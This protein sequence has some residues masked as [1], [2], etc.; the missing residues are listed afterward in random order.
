MVDA[1]DKPIMAMI[2]KMERKRTELLTELEKVQEWLS[3]FDAI[4]NRGKAIIGEERVTIPGL[5]VKLIVDE[6]KPETKAGRIL[7]LIGDKPDAEK[8][9]A[10]KIRQILEES[11][12]PLSI[13]KIDAQFL[14]R[15]WPINGK[16]RNQ[17]IRNALLSK[18]E[19]F[20]RSPKDNKIWDLRERIEQ[21]AQAQ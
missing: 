14:E 7:R 11:G 18:P 5:P 6:E 13:P 2:A 12:G 20:A 19:W 16:N 3:Q 4:L 9:H 21:S 15:E 17:I 8:T 10:E 1:E